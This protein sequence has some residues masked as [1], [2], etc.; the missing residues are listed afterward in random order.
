MLKNNLISDTDFAQ[1]GTRVKANA[2]FNSFRRENSL[3]DLESQLYEHIDLLRKEETTTPNAYEKRKASEKTMRAMEKKDRIKEALKNLEQ[4]RCEKI[5]N[6]IRNNDKPTQEELDDVRASTTDPEVRKMK[7]GDGGYR[8]AY[9]IQ[10]ATGLDSRVIYG[11]D[12]VNTLDPGTAPRLMAQVNERLQSLQMS[13][14]KRWIADAAYSAKNDLITIANLFPNC[15]FFAPPKPNKQI[16]P[17]KHVKKDHEAVII[18]R[19]LIGT[20]QITELYKKRCSTAEFSNMHIKNQALREF[21]VRGLMK[22]KGMAL[23]HAVSMN[24]SRAINLLKKN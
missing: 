24:I 18:W 20:T 12:V 4:F 7:M 19:D 17:K 21:S 15:L 14:I 8:L 9:N 13:E 6:G 5:K 3:K 16:D 10:F 11:V 1:D 2:G 23:L 22:V